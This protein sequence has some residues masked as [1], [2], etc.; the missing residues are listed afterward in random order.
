MCGGVAQ[1]R[2]E[3]IGEIAWGKFYAERRELVANPW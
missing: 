1:S 2:D 3:D